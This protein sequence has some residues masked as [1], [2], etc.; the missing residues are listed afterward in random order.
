MDKGKQIFSLSKMQ[1]TDAATVFIRCPEIRI[2]ET[3]VVEQWINLF[4]DILNSVENKREETMY[5]HCFRLLKMVK[6][7]VPES[8]I[9]GVYNV[10]CSTGNEI[11]FTVKFKTRE[12]REKFFVELEKLEEEFSNT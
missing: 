1:T 12:D 7:S 8:E 3:T 9:W 10:P 6:D 4:V 2:M 11:M 5:E